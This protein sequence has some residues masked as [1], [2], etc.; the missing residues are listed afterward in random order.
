MSVKRNYI[1]INV[2]F[3]TISLLILQT[4]QAQAD[5]SSLDQQL[6]TNQKAM[7]NS[8]VV[9]V[10]KRGDT[11]V[12]KKELGEFNSKTP[13]PIGH[14]STWLTAALV[15]QF[16]DEGKLSLDDKITRW[17]PEFEKYGKNYITLRL[18]LSHMT[19]IN[20]ESK[21]L[22][23]LFEK[24]KFSS[25]EDEVN[26]FAAREIR[27]N[28][29]TDFWYGNIGADIVGRVLEVVGK[30]K[31]D[32]LIK[33]K[34]FNPMTMRKSSFTTLDGSALDPAGGAT[35]TADDYMKFLVMLLNNGIY[36]GKQIL[37][38][39]AVKELL[40]IRTTSSIIKF[41]PKAA[42]GLNYALGSW[43]I[44]ESDGKATA[45]SSLGLFGTWPV[46]DLCH[47]YASLIITKDLLD[48]PK[49]DTWKSIKQMIDA[50]LPSTCQ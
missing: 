20:D 22:K 35:T 3:I 8:L 25:L 46:I 38:E 47:G 29:G 45:L 24:K 27:T 41:A 28:P 30:K 21:F 18:C 40:Q 39:A 49:P 15:M 7:G 9:M 23:K 1:C 17:L 2:I 34:L 37:S 48:D 33:Q 10:W 16:V 36:A 31:F 13:A 26:S 43:V 6:K 4:V 14:A 12:Y 11:L 42:A 50:Q 5:W 32:V 19:G 44:E